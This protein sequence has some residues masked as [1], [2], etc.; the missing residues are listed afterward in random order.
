[1]GLN[2]LQELKRER[3]AL[4]RKLEFANF[5][6]DDSKRRAQKARDLYQDAGLDM[7]K[8]EADIEIVRRE[9]EQV[10]RHKDA[11]VEQIRLMKE[12][13]GVANWPKPC[14]HLEVPED[15]VGVF[16]LEACSFCNRWYT[17]F[18]IVMASCKHLYH[19][20]CVAK[21]V[22]T[23]NSCVICKEH[24]H[25]AW[26]RS[27]GFRSP[28]SD[29]EGAVG[30][31]AITRSMEELTESLKDSF[32]IPIPECKLKIYSLLQSH[33]QVLHASVAVLSPSPLDALVRPDTTFV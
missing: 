32:G 15:G 12:G 7:W 11:V 33:V 4:V 2:R 22:E 5:S 29:A 28:L 23:Q 24:F 17:A 26:L 19:P 21:L 1:M 30:A 16:E 10:R 13:G 8:Y 3:E 27:F 25:P 6:L 31:K 20:F 9:L 18:D 14:L